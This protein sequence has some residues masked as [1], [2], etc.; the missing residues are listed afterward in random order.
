MQIGRA[1]VY[2]HFEVKTLQPDQTF[3]VD[4]AGWSKLKKVRRKL[5]R[6][7]KLKMEPH[8]R[9]D[10]RDP[11]ETAFRSATC[12]M[13]HWCGCSLIKRSRR[14]NHVLQALARSTRKDVSGWLI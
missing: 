13:S 7:Y 12:L 11:G 1:S 6:K 8:F 3:R 10:F 14:R 9:C 4:G 5:T 2:G